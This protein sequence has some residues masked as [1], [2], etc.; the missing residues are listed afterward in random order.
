[1]SSFKH[2]LTVASLRSFMV[3]FHWRWILSQ[4]RSRSLTPKRF[5][6]TENRKSKIRVVSGLRTVPFSSDSAYD[7]DTYDSVKT[8]LSES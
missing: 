3:G 6:P 8:R 2:R 7:S 4:S 5:R 1:M